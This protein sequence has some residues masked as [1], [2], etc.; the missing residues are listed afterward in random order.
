MSFESIRKILS[1]KVQAGTGTKDMR[2][3]HVFEAVR[4]VLDVEWG[5]EKSALVKPISFTEGTLKLE[6]SSSAAKQEL[7]VQAARLKNE[8]N[9]RLG[10]LVVRQIVVSLR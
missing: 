9:R 7:G 2:I 6:T 4:S 1:L 8:L 10:A 5:V 3:A